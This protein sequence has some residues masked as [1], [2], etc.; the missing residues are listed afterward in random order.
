MNKFILKSFS[1]I[2]LSLSLVGCFGNE[3]R[4]T[5][6]NPS[7]EGYYRF[8]WG[9][10]PITLYLFNEDPD[11]KEHEGIFVLSNSSSGE[12]FRGTYYESGDILYCNPDEWR[13]GVISMNFKYN[14]VGS[15]S[16][17]LWWFEDSAPARSYDTNHEY[18]FRYRYTKELY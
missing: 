11:S 7:Y 17:Y 10:R 3:P 4:K 8:D 2:L 16:G 15:E 1:L 13:Y 5:E 9:G 18:C 12:S 14:K 6:P